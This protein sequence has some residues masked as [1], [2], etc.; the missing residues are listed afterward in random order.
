MNRNQASPEPD[1]WHSLLAT[2]RKAVDNI[3]TGIIGL[4]VA[5][6]L[7][8]IAERLASS[9][10]L[11]STI[12]Y[13]LFEL[14]SMYVIFST[15][16][17]HNV[18]CV[19]RYIIRPSPGKSLLNGVIWLISILWAIPGLLAIIVLGVLDIK[20]LRFYQYFLLSLAAVLM[21]FSPIALWGE[22]RELWEMTVP[23]GIVLAFYMPTVIEILH[24]L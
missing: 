20:S 2:I 12:F 11:H 17:L 5:F 8:K 13:V 10:S 24:L 21:T 3:V 6:T 18:Y 23:V 15:V 19:R 16:I 14:I 7:T 4:P 22:R 1:Q 9:P